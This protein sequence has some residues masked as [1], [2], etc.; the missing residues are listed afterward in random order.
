MVILAVPEELGFAF[1][2][3]LPDAGWAKSSSMG[4]GGTVDLALSQD[5]A[6]LTVGWYS[7]ITLY[8]LEFTSNSPA[9]LSSG[10]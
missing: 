5:D 4:R 10:R 8:K 3:S 2:T 9:S 1:G 6:Y 7:N